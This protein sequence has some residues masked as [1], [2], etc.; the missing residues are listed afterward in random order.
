MEL[1]EWFKLQAKIVRFF[2]DKKQ[3]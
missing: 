1:S 3:G 2:K